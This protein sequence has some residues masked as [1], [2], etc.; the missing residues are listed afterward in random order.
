MMAPLIDHDRITEVYEGTVGSREFQQASRRRIHWMCAKVT[1]RDVLDVGCSQGIASILLGR[2]G[3]RVTGIDREHEP[4]RAARE[5]LDQEEPQVRER[6]AFQIGEAGELQFENG[7]FDAVLLGEVLEHQLDPGKPLDEARRVLRP[8]GRLV[9]T[10]PYG[11]HPYPDHKDPLYLSSLLGKLAPELSIAEIDLVDGYLGLVAERSDDRA[12]RVWRR[13]LGVA[14]RRLADQDE[15][16]ETLRALVNELREAARTLERS[17]QDQELTRKA[18][19]IQRDAAAQRQHELQAQLG[20]LRDRAAA[21]VVERD[22]A[23][24]DLEEALEQIRSADRERSAAAERAGELEAER[25]AAAREV[26][27]LH[28]EVRRARERLQAI[29]LGHQASRAELEAARA[30]LGEADTERER[31]ADQLLESQRQL[32]QERTRV[33]ALESQLDMARR[34]ASDTERLLRERDELARAAAEAE[35][36][37]AERSAL[38]A[39]MERLEAQAGLARS[40]LTEA[41]TRMA[42][43][44][45][46]REA[47]EDAALAANRKA[48]QS[49]LEVAGSAKAIEAL[50][51]EAEGLR[52]TVD[53]LTSEGIALRGALND[54]EAALAKESELR[55][56]V[57]RRL[58]E[59]SR[60]GEQLEEDLAAMRGR[61]GYRIGRFFGRPFRRG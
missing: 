31:L 20:E 18:A 60:R 37:E 13:A 32:Q 52:T 19:E 16:V 24:R 22:R 34:T 50:R 49:A 56:D 15:T 51:S 9:I 46:E 41:R 1:G 2:E 59:A 23:M 57:E 45:A 10:T 17:M 7:S 54:R 6:V 53:A 25:T 33:S 39:R 30:Q 5:R 8:G 43:L 12:R 3:H 61:L 14:E 35:R 4:I 44:I 21:A 11:V 47:A 28:G 38:A 55:Q 29:E 36:V 27:E 42:E 40:R 58:D 48:E 26:D